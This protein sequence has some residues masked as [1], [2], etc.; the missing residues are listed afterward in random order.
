MEK[1]SEIAAA[2]N[3]AMDE[4]RVEERI[5]V[6][7]T[8]LDVLFVQGTQS[9]KNIQFHKLLLARVNDYRSKRG[10]FGRQVAIEILQSIKQS[11]GRFLQK[12]LLATIDAQGR[13]LS[14]ATNDW[15]EILDEEVIIKR[16]TRRLY[17][18]YK[19]LNE[20]R[21]NCSSMQKSESSGKESSTALEHYKDS[22]EYNCHNSIQD[23][24]HSH[25]SQQEYLQQPPDESEK[26][27]THDHLGALPLEQ[28]QP[29]A[30][31][32]APKNLIKR[33]ALLDS[34]LPMQP[35]KRLKG[36]Q[37]GETTL[38]A[39]ELTHHRKSLAEFD[40]CDKAKITKMPLQLPL[41]ESKKSV[42]ATKQLQ[43]NMDSRDES[44][45]EPDDSSKNTSLKVDSITETM[46]KS[47]DSMTPAIQASNGVRDQSCFVEPTPRDILLGKGN[48]S[49]QA[50]NIYYHNLVKERMNDYMKQPKWH[51]NKQLAK[52][53]IRT[54][55]QEGRRFFQKD[56]SII[57]D[58]QSKKHF[59]VTKN[60]VEVLDENVIIAI[61][62]TL[63]QNIKQSTKRALLEAMPTIML[64]GSESSDVVLEH[65]KMCLPGLGPIMEA[66]SSPL[67]V[68]EQPHT[69]P[70][71]NLRLDLQG[72]PLDEPQR[73][74]DASVHV[75]D[76]SPSAIEGASDPM[77]P[78][79]PEPESRVIVQHGGNT[80]EQ[81]SDFSPPT[82]AAPTAATEG[83]ASTRD[84]V[85]NLN[86]TPFTDNDAA[87][88]SVQ[89][90]PLPVGLVTVP[91][92][93]LLPVGERMSEENAVVLE[94]V[95]VDQATMNSTHHFR[96][97][98]APEQH[99]IMTDE[100]APALTQNGMPVDM[101]GTTAT[102]NALIATE[103]GSTTPQPDIM[104]TQQPQ[105][106][107]VIRKQK[108]MLAISLVEADFFKGVTRWGLPVWREGHLEESLRTST[109]MQNSN[110][111]ITDNATPQ[112]NWQAL[113][114][115]C[116]SERDLT[117]AVDKIFVGSLHPRTFA[118]RII[119]L[120]EKMFMVA[121]G[122]DPSPSTLT[123]VVKWFHSELAQWAAALQTAD[124]FRNFRPFAYSA[125][126][127][128]HDI[129][130]AARDD[131][132]TLVESLDSRTCKRIIAA[133]ANLS[134]FRCIC[135]K[136][137]DLKSLVSVVNLATLT[138]CGHA[139]PTIDMLERAAETDMYLLSMFAKTQHGLNVSEQVEDASFK[140]FTWLIQQLHLL[141]EVESATVAAQAGVTI[142]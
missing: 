89:D 14:L 77:L 42:V 122:F 131:R 91:E 39:P 63:V 69:E 142:T 23:G 136:R 75:L 141:M 26:N 76:V 5:P 20:K 28:P 9:N 101:P 113:S 123:P 114:V 118:I 57:I 56:R 41:N 103:N 30:G 54:M 98:T 34:V 139:A 64:Q 24:G 84:Q 83:S 79:S 25:E 106:Q 105:Q 110:S 124:G 96:L 78:L 6:I 55:K 31:S 120:L 47:N 67:D 38:A 130:G 117:N 13:K 129:E 18:V 80:L 133:A 32:I 2:A 49:R 50:G 11:G 87:L 111:S 90:N 137:S 72:L 35:A 60:W 37:D 93:P 82:C 68:H 21:A 59:T 12:K 85:N 81:N 115:A 97:A 65:G 17:N 119:G 22:R 33:P 71:K 43:S 126:D 52:E 92:Q 70:S 121:H 58:L 135:E 45:K 53:V 127:L 10:F 74:L 109:D 51:F 88:V 86:P 44:I 36:L 19:L 104:P 40:S 108:G 138:L 66:N 1:G 116:K 16:I 102:K 73:G 62:S 94:Q 7:P 48:L 15:L 125:E 61:I 46:E 8:P 140:R 112:F 27:S 132:T 29:P 128:C 99:G 4:E 95:L 3:E 134:R 100:L 107:Q